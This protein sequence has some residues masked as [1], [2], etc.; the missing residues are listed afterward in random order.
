MAINVDQSEATA[1]MRNLALA[2]FGAGLH[3]LRHPALRPAFPAGRG[4]GRVLPRHRRLPHVLVPQEGGRHRH[5]AVPHRA[6][7]YVLAAPLSALI[8]DHVDWFGLSS[9]R[10]MFILEGA[11]A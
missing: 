5:R 8:M 10:W 7:S 9:W 3:P 4:R 2:R 6:A 1:T 11:P